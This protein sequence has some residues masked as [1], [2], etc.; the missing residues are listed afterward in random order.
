MTPYSPPY[1]L[2]D[3]MLRLVERISEKAD[4]VEQYEDFSAHP[5]LRRN[6]RIQSLHASLAIE[7][8]SLC[9]EEVRDVIDGQ[10][11]LGSR[12]EIQEVKNAYRAYEKI[13]LVDPYSLSDLKLLQGLLTAGLVADAGRFR[14]H[15]EGVFD[16]TRCIFMTPPAQAVSHLMEEL[17]SWMRRNENGVHPLIL[18][19]VFHYEFVFI[20]PFTDGNGRTARLWQTIILTHWKKL[21]QYLP[22]ESQIKRCQQEYYEAIAQCHREGSSSAFIAFMLTIIDRSLEAALAQISQHGEN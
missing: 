16:G 18:S 7:G 22:L 2:S 1:S 9:E 13:G 15:G 21:F 4:S 10:M 19:S 6:N 14:T 12:Q 3:Q 17:F 20:H 8:N 11:V 5:T